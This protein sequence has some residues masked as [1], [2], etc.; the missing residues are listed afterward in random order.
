MPALSVTANS[1]VNIDATTDTR[2]AAET[3]TAGQSLYAPAS[4]TCGLADSDA[5]GK[6]TVIGVALNG[7]A[8]GQ[9]IVYAKT[10]GTITLGATM[11]AGLDYYLS[12]TA[13]GIEV[14][15]GVTSGCR[16]VRIG[17]ATTTT[18]LYIDIKD[19][20]VTL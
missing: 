4:T 10:G 14:V 2:L 13:G 8:T 11:V 20:G 1:C 3:I 12:A 5:A 6:T 7:G 15:A 19:Y 17:Y 16:K 18:I 9:P